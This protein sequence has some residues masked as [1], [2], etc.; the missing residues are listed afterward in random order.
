MSV[1]YDAFTGAFLSKITERDLLMLQEDVRTEIVDGYMKRAVAQFRHVCKY[2]LVGS[3]DDILRI[4]DIDI[5]AE[6]LDE[7]L[8]IVS[9]GMVVQWLKPF[10][11]KQ[12]LYKNILSTKDFSA[13]SPAELLLRVGGAYKDAKDAYTQMIREYSYN[14][15][16]LTEL[17]L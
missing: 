15:G 17:H 7:I 12:E 13:Y 2:D 8:D 9:E 6:E 5:K 1:P 11:F 3:A 4:F 14:A 16:D 10:M